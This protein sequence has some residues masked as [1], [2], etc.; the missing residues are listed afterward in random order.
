A[1]KKSLIQPAGQI[2]RDLIIREKGNLDRIVATLG[3]KEMTQGTLVRKL[4]TYTTTNPTRQALF[5]YDRL[6]R[7]IYTLKYLRDPQLERNIRRSQ[8][9]IESYHQLRAAV[10]K[11][12]GKKELT[13][14]NDIE[15]DISNQCGRLI[16]N[17]IVYYNSAILSRLLERLE[18]EGNAKGIEALTRISP[19]AWQHILL[20]GHYTF[21]SSN[22]IIDLDA[23][24]AGLKLG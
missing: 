20:N 18:A 9:R 1:Y 6:V 23:L 16:S 14:K 7:S 2:D 4:C 10:A 15:T 8:N 13:G 19:V 17:A 3:L 5:E 24:V 21:Q 11:V 12:G 22:E